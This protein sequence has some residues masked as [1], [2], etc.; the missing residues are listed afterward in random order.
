[1]LLLFSMCML[2]YIYLSFFFFS[3]LLVFTWVVGHLCLF[4]PMVVFDN[5]YLPLIFCFQKKNFYFWDKKTC[6]VTQN[7]QKTKI[8]LK[9]Q[10]MKE[11]ENMQKHCFFF[12]FLVFTWVVGPLYLFPP[13]VVFGNCFFSLFSVFI[14]LFYF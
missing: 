2:K 4:P 1:M 6:L 3:F 9:T 14:F 5:Y 11:T 10:F 13:M 12:F 7:G 8:V